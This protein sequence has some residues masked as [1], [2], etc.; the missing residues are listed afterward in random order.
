MAVRVVQAPIFGDRSDATTLAMVAA[1]LRR[2]KL[3]V[4]GV[5][6]R[7]AG[8]LA[9]LAATPEPA[10]IT[11]EIVAQLERIAAERAIAARRQFESWCTSHELKF[12]AAPSET[13][14]DH[15]SASWLESDDTDAVAQT[16][17]LSDLTVMARGNEDGAISNALEAAMFRTGKPVLLAPAATPRDMFGTAVVAWNNSQEAARAV[18]LALPLLVEMNRVVIYSAGEERRKAGAD[19]LRQFLAWHGIEATGMDITK[20]AGAIGADLLAEARRL[21]AGLVVMGAYTH[22]RLR[23]LVFGGVTRHIL[24]H[25]DLPIL[26]AH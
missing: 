22:S 21:G 9:L 17:R 11:A 16:G 12:A 3:H 1:L 15:S 5:H 24:H 13:T 8:E 6:P 14:I 19:T 2:L 26:L 23:Q 4:H 25:A 20:S 7:S 10:V 18:A